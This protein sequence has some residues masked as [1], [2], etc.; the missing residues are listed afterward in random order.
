MGWGNYLIITKDQDLLMRYLRGRLEK[1]RRFQSVSLGAKSGRYLP[2]GA[3]GRRLRRNA[4]L[5]NVWE[6]CLRWVRTGWRL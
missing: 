4:V 3:H 1:G 2:H 6:C 5:R